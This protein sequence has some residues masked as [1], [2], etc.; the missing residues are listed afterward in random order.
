MGPQSDLHG[1][2]HS[3]LS[4]SSLC[5]STGHYYELTHIQEHTMSHTTT[6]QAHI[7]P[8]PDS[9]GYIVQPQCPWDAAN[10]VLHWLDTGGNGTEYMSF[11]EKCAVR[12]AMGAVLIYSQA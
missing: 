8:D 12:S 1:A 11:E 5:S 3:V 4:A 6:H 10:D 9:N 2:K 7:E